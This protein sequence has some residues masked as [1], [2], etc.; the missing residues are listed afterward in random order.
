MGNSLFSK[1]DHYRYP[2]ML[3]IVNMKYFI[4]LL[5]IGLLTEINCHVPLVGQTSER[6]VARV[7][8]LM[9]TVGAADS[10]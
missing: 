4:F 8:T 6:Q 9:P 3:V 5:L 7:G 2:R 10:E 1:T